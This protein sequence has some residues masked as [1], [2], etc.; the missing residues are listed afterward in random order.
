VASVVPHQSDVVLAAL[1]P[2][3]EAEVVEEDLS[4]YRKPSKEKT[5]RSVC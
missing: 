2:T 3:A 1:P 4:M 5:L